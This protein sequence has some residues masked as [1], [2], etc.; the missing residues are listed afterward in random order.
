MS[1]SQ[2]EGWSFDPR[3]LRESPQRSLG[4][5]VNLNRHDRKH[6]QASACCQLSLNNSVALHAINKIKRSIQFI[7]NIHSTDFNT[8]CFSK[9]SV[10]PQCLFFLKEHSAFKKGKFKIPKQKVNGQIFI[11]CS[12]FKLFLHATV[13]FN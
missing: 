8:V 6:F 12:A 10:F 1:A 5:S 4:K 11:F 7:F 13:S 2:L 9:K 3:P